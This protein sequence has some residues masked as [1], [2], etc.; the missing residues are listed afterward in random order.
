[1]TRVGSR[2][3]FNNP[4]EIQ[5]RAETWNKFQFDTYVFNDT[6]EYEVELSYSTPKVFLNLEMIG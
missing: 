5:L 3:E 4:F 2:I 6:Y 1:M